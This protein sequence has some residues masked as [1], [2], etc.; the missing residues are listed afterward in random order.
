MQ[1]VKKNFYFKFIRIL[2][3]FTIIG[4]LV[5]KADYNLD[6][7]YSKINEGYSKIILIVLLHITFMNFIS[8]RM[9]LVFKLGIKN[10]L[11]YFKWSKL[12][13]ESLALNL[14]LSH[15]G[16]VY[17]AYELNKYNVRYRTYLSFFYVLFFSYIIFKHF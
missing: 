3:F 17:R 8:L 12:Y 10:F 4:Y 14:V 9:F 7:I 5:F 1:N 11:Y 15:T 2:I 16:T 13:F 6:Q